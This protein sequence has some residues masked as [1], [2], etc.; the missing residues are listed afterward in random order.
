MARLSPFLNQDDTFSS[1]AA[2]YTGQVP[3]VDRAELTK[4]LGNYKTGGKKITMGAAKGKT[5]QQLYNLAAGAVVGKFREAKKKAAPK[6]PA[7]KISQP[8]QT[9][10]LSRSQAA[11]IVRRYGLDPAKVFG[12][13]VSGTST[14]WINSPAASYVW[15][16][17]ESFESWLKRTYNLK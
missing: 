9:T 1:I 8:K 10:R 15:A 17:P 7:Q 5:D 6:P 16:S 4:L 13:G 2:G 3:P 14:G 11:S 12:W